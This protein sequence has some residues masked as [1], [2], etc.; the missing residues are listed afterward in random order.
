M[1]KKVGILLLGI[2]AVLFCFHAVSIYFTQDAYATDHY[3]R[4][5]WPCPDDKT[6]KTYCTLGG[7]ELCTPQYCNKAV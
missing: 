5:D 4:Q 6:E 2:L 1:I 3:Y 7:N